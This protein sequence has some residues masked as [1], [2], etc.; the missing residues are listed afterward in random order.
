MKIKKLLLFLPPVIAGLITAFFRYQMVEKTVDPQTGIASSHSWIYGIYFFAA[1]MALLFLAASVLLGKGGKVEIKGPGAMGYRLLGAGA[2]L[3]FVL[4]GGAYFFSLSGEN[5]GALTLV[6]AL[7]AILCGGG[8]LAGLL[9]KNKEGEGAKVCLLLPVFYSAFSLLVFYRDNNANPLVYSFA[10]ELFAYIAVMFTL[11]GAAAFFF[12]KS[13]PRLVLFASLSSIYLLVTVLCSDNLLPAFT[14]GH[15]HFTVG[16]LLSLGA[17]L[18]LSGAWLL[19]LRLP[20][21]G[22]K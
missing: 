17:F 16:D 13:R 1:L 7:A 22:E 4:S 9:A 19:A 12:G 8:L 18:L 2:A 21:L 20:K 3:L 10:T 11:Y 14:Q 5:A 6:K 15:I